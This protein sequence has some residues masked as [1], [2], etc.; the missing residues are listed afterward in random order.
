MRSLCVIRR[1]IDFCVHLVCPSL[2]CFRAQFRKPCDVSMRTAW[3][4]RLTDASA[5]RKKKKTSCRSGEVLSFCC[6]RSEHVS[7][8]SGQCLAAEC[9]TA[10]ELTR[11]SRC[12]IRCQWWLI[13][14]KYSP[15]GETFRPANTFITAQR[16]KWTNTITLGSRNL[17]SP[18]K[19]PHQRTL[20][21]STLPSINAGL[22]FIASTGRL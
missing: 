11:S 1:E 16:N 18:C 6:C 2:L 4:T 7:L 12:K 10:A 19:H 5:P 21:L 8:S 20:P 22:Y 3:I 14:R 17:T 9:L 15:C 13:W